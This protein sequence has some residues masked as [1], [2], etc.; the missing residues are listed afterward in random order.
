MATIT[1]GKIFRSDQDNYDGI[2]ATSRTSSSGGTQTGLKIGNHVDVLS[3]FGGGDT[4]NM[5]DTIISR[6]VSSL[7]SAN[8]CLE[9]APGTWTISN[10]IT[11]ASNFTVYAPAGCVFSVASGKTMTVAGVFLRE[12]ATYSSGAGTFTISGT[13]YAPG[14]GL[15][16]NATGERLQISDTAVTLGGGGLYYVLSSVTDGG[17]IFS[18]GSTISLGASLVLYGESHVA[19]AKDILLRSSANPIVQWDDSVGKLYLYS[20]TGTPAATLTL[21]T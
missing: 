10:T 4:A 5:T 8:I 14:L 2:L 18:G 20:G 1:K 6:A 9:F 16:D 19:S 15:D 12:H 13:D 7:G 3:V 21:G 11:I 17:V